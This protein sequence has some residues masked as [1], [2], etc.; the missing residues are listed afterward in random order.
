[1]S[2]GSFSAYSSNDQED[3]ASRVNKEKRLWSSE[4]NVQTLL[5]RIQTEKM[6]H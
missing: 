3:S 4:E 5:V 2:L 1:M 6:G